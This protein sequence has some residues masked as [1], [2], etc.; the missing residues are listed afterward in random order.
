[1]NK[2]HFVKTLSNYYADV[3]SG[4]KKAELRLNDRDY[5]VGDHLVLMEIDKFTYKLTGN[6]HEVA[7][8]H[9]FQSAQLALQP[10]FCMLSIE[11]T[12]VDSEDLKRIAED[13]IKI[14]Q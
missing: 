10:G 5:K 6:W 14:N 11:P 2:R 13:W 4:K 9:F 1:M 8:T 12:N 7:V 3:V